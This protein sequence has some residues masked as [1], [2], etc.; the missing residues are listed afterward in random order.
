MKFV[1]LATAVLS[2]ADVVTAG[3]VEK[4]QS[5]N[6]VSPPYYPAPKGGW[7]SDW[8]ASYAK[9]QALVSKMTLAGKVNITTTVGWSMGRCVGNTGPVYGLFPSICAQDGPLG[10]RYADLITAFP[11]GITTGATWDKELMY[12]RANAMGAEFRGKG[13]H[14]ALG[15]SVGP[16]GRAPLGGRNWEGFGSD[17]YL[18]GVAAYE[19]VRGIQ[20]NGVQATIK[21]YVANEQEHFRGD[22]GVSNTISSNVD[23]RTM[24]EVYLWPFAEGVRAGV[25]SVMCSYNMVS[26]YYHSYY[27]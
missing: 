17:P 5:G 1:T 20:D 9:A 8:S 12:Q 3:V 25:A 23:D 14:V 18:Q 15:P 4:R 26:I 24:H 11:A 27:E 16:L 10:V 19:S 2:A 6:Y 21:H 13:V 7:V 22:N